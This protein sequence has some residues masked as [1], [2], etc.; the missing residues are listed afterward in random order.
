M[1][2]SKSA[3]TTVMVTLESIRMPEIKILD[4]LGLEQQFYCQCNLLFSL[5]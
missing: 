3:P 4:G 5:K 2:N 1:L